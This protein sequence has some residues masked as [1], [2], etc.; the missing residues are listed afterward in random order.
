MKAVILA[1][2]STKEQE[3]H[4]HSLPAQVAKLKEYAARHNFEIARE[5]VF[6][7]SAGTKIRNRFEE[8]LAY[9]K[10]HKD[11]NV[12]LCQ[13]VD[14]ATRNFSDAVDIDNMRINED[15][16]V[17][18]V[19]DGFVLNKNASGADMFMWEA[20]VFIAKQYI[21][22]LRDDSMRSMYYKL[23]SGEC[24]TQAPLGYVNITDPITNRKTVGLDKERAFLMTQMFMEY[25]TGC[26]TIPELTEKI[27]QWGLTSKKGH[28]L[29]PN[30]VHKM[31][32]NEFYC[33]YMTIRDKRYRHKY[34]QII[35]EVTFRKCQ[36]VRE[37]A[38][39]KPFK[40]AN[41]PFVFRGLLHCADC[42]CAYSSDIKKGKYIYL[43]PTKSKG[44]CDCYALTEKAVLAQVNDVLK[45]MALPAQ[46]ID[47]LKGKLQESVISKKALHEHSVQTIQSDY[48]LVQA[49]LDRLLDA[50]IAG[51]IT[52]NEYDK[53]AYELKD[54]QRELNSYMTLHTDAD[55]DFA[56]SVSTL[57]EL[58]SQAYE[59]FQ[60]SE[61]EQKRQLLKFL[62]TNLQIKGG[63]LQYALNRPFDLM[64]ILADTLKWSG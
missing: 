22:R 62:F 31:L 27:S 26:Y 53:K 44:T 2:V 64:P 33:G 13:N 32:R 30:N 34:E 5:F 37:G 56:I 52:Q 28:K 46:F 35:D 8:V 29:R 25:S 47:Q 3:E 17:H 20:K 51:S 10:R 40:Y 18:F 41:K 19:Q 48:D 57:L 12:L 42:Q 16:E 15:L 1:R 21:N 4:G 43:R 45:E 54:R 9:L 14:R 58:C 11:V 55:E 24:V 50:L 63:K 38:N 39:K 61:V 7:E 6:S 59:T 49:K 23:E 36:R 60:S